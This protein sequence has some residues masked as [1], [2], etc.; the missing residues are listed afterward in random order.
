MRNFKSLRKK[1]NWRCITQKFRSNI[2][3]VRTLAK[4]KVGSVFW[5]EEVVVYG[6]ASFINI[7]AAP[8]NQCLSSID[9]NIEILP[10]L[11][12]CQCQIHAFYYPATLRGRKNKC[13]QEYFGG[14]ASSRMVGAIWSKK[15]TIGCVIWTVPRRNNVSQAVRPETPSANKEMAVASGSIIHSRYP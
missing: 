8:P 2:N 7:Q 1:S 9:P 10:R 3:R 13:P 5:K 15:M 12:S 14:W 4:H 11:V 6:H